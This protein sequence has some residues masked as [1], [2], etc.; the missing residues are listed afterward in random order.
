MKDSLIKPFTPWVNSGIVYAIDPATGVEEVVEPTQ[1]PEEIEAD[2]I[3]TLVSDAETQSTAISNDPTGSLQTATTAAGNIQGQLDTLLPQLAANPGLQT[4][5]DSL[6]TQLT[7]AE[8]TQTQAYS[9]QQQALQLNQ[10]GMV[11]AANANPSSLIE[12]ATT[13][14]TAVTPDQLLNPTTGQAPDVGLADTAV[15]ADVAQ[16]EAPVATTTNTMD[17]VLTEAA[18][19]GIIDDTSAATGGPSAQAT[20]QGQLVSLM[21]DFEGGS[22]PIWASG[23]MRKAMGTMQAR[24]MGASSLAGAAV[25]QAAMESALSIAV[26]DAGT[27]AQFEMQSLN[28]EQQTTIFKTQQRMASLFSDQAATNASSQFNATSQNQ[29]DQFFSGLEARSSE[30]NAAQVNAIMQF[31]AGE[32]NTVEK[33]NTS[34]EAQ[35]DQFNAQNSLVISQ[36]NAVWRQQVATAGTSAQNIANLEH[37]RNVSAITGAALDQIWQRERDLMDYA[38]TGSES[39]LDRSTSIVLAKLGADSSLDAIKLRQDLADDTAKSAFL[40]NLVSSFLF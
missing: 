31:N 38:F 28:N 6:I 2:R 5:V 40:G 37:T 14:T 22:T 13:A 9:Q 20:V 23:A 3:A 19:E 10:Q 27:N 25:V 36:S 26:Q 4:Q 18:A 16:A 1:T 12:K 17:V 39:E 8:R 21:E 29:T 15:V 30:F 11:T 34:L 33:F 7:A 35:R 24:G 32:T